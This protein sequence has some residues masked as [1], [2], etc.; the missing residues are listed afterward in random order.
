MPAMTRYEK[1]DAQH[2]AEAERKIIEGAE[3][4]QPGYGSESGY[5]ATPSAP[6]V[7]APDPEGVMALVEW[8]RGKWAADNFVPRLVS[9]QPPMTRYEK[10]DAYDAEL[11]R[12]GANNEYVIEDGSRTG[13]AMSGNMIRRLSENPGDTFPWITA[14]GRLYWHCHRRHPHHRSADRPYW[15]GA[16]CHQAVTLVVKRRFSPAN[17]A[18]ILKL[19][20]IDPLLVSAFREIETQIDDARARA[21]KRERERA[22]HYSLFEGPVMEHR[23]LDGL[24]RAECP[25]CRVRVAS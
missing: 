7:P 5:T 6:P 17:A 8:H 18:K 2:D 11:Q 15:R 1:S 21:E 3:Y 9:R 22:G 12:Y 13:M 14:Y 19:D 10:S 20:H 23:P 25:A 4:T 24:H 16:L